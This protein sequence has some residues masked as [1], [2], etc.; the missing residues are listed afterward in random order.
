MHYVPRSIK[1]CPPCDLAQNPW[2]QEQI[3]KNQGPHFLEWM[4]SIVKC[5][6]LVIP[7]V[8]APHIWKRWFQNGDRL[9]KVKKFQ[10]WHVHDFKELGFKASPSFI[11]YKHPFS[12]PIQDNGYERLKTYVFNQIW[13]RKVL[14]KK[15]RP[16]LK[17]SSSKL[18]TCVGQNSFTLAYNHF[19][20]G[21][22]KLVW[23]PFA[24]TVSLS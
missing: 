23:P 4:P 11:R 2:V 24:P 14:T 22:F 17:L 1:P 7:H 20:A 19:K 5:Q 16:T 8:E 10:P 18:N 13:K 12:T 3:S 15:E 6:T 9:A 21:I